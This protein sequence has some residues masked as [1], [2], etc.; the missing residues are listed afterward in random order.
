[1]A[2]GMDPIS[3]GRLHDP[4]VPAPQLFR[5]APAPQ[6]AHLIRHFWVPVWSFPAG[7]QSHQRVL[8]YPSTLL[9][10]APDYAIAK[11][12]EPELSHKVLRGS[13]WAFGVLFQAAAGYRLHGAGLPALV[14]NEAPL[15][16]ALPEL[17]EAVRSVRAEMAA[18]PSSSEVHRRCM[19]IVSEG[20]A[21]WCAPLDEEDSLINLIT[22][23]VEQTPTLTRV[24][25]LAAAVGLD[26]RSLQRLTRKRLGLSP[27]WLIQRRRLQ[28]AGVRLAVGG[29]SVGQ[30]ATELGYADQAHFTRDFSRVTGLTPGEYVK[31]N[32]P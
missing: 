4:T 13:S 23:H 14:G 21:P 28:E 15:I 3:R 9:V 27:K 30:L 18:A 25:K 2:T 19:A 16:D 24:D 29:C 11:G 8:Q 22:D 12:P 5:Y 10:I 32:A 7:V 31:L 1:M 26:E 20:L 17:G 6:Y